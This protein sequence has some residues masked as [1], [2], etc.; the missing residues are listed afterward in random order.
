MSDT[1]APVAPPE[2]DP[3]EQHGPPPTPTPTPSPTPKT[4]PKVE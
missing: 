3:T 2:D 4:E 1:N